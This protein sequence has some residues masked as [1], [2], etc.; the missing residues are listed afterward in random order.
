MYD[1]SVVGHT[2]HRC[3]QGRNR[4]QAGPYPVVSAGPRVDHLRKRYS[5]FLRF[6]G[7][8]ISAKLSGRRIH[9]VQKNEPPKEHL[10][11]QR[12]KQEAAGAG[13]THQCIIPDG[14]RIVRTRGRPGR[15]PEVAMSAER[16]SSPYAC[17]PIRARGAPWGCTANRSEGSPS[18]NHGRPQRSDVTRLLAGRVGRRLSLE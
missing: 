10:H 16:P 11:H 3:N 18:G 17:L 14:D 12:R 7:S 2:Q 4:Q 15:W 13:Q 6:T 5:T 1:C 8:F 9:S